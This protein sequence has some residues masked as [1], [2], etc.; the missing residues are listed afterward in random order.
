MERGLQQLC[1]PSSWVQW[2][3]VGGPQSIKS[4]QRFLKG[5]QKVWASWLGREAKPDR[6]LLWTGQL[7]TH[8]CQISSTTRSESSQSCLITLLSP[9][10]SHMQVW[11][12]RRAPRALCVSNPHNTTRSPFTIS[13]SPWYHFSSLPFFNHYAHI[14]LTRHPASRR[15]GKTGRGVTPA[16]PACSD[17]PR[18]AAAAAAGTGPPVRT[19][20][21]LPPQGNPYGFYTLQSNTGLSQLDANIEQL[22]FM[23]YLK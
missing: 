5:G 22:L 12:G 7:K 23:S 18:L 15:R 4:E 1:D 21:L 13:T 3:G 11:F 19:L 9:Q 16:L 17:W 14:T 10:Q 2:R 20:L 8:C 6:W